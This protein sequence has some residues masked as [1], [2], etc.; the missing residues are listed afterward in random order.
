METDRLFLLY[1]IGDY[2]VLILYDIID[3]Y[4]TKKYHII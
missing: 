1:N 2:F 3:E 4:D